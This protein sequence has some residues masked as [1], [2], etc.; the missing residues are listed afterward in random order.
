[1]VA[2][3]TAAP[4]RRAEDVGDFRGFGL[5]VPQSGSGVLN[6]IHCMSKGVEVLIPIPVVRSYQYL[7]YGLQSAVTA[8]D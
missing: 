8:L 7:D 2:A 3:G 5:H 4:D 6:S 1:M